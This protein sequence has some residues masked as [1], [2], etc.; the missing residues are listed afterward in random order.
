VAGEL[1]TGI[2]APELAPVTTGLGEIYQYVCDPNL[3]MNINMAQ[4]S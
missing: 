3:D 2:G 1:P 4:R